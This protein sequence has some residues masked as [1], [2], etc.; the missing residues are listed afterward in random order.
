MTAAVWSTPPDDAAFS[1][2]ARTLIQFLHNHHLLQLTGK[3]NWLTLKNGS[4]SYVQRIVDQLP[5]GHLHMNTPVITVEPLANGGAI[6]HTTEK[7][8]H[9]DHV[10]FACHA[11]TTLRLLGSHASAEEQDILGCFQFGKNTAVL[12]SDESVSVDP[13]HDVRALTAMQMMPRLRSC[14][15][16]WNYLTFTDKTTGKPNVN[17][18]SL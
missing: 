5:Q 18:V 13:F 9:F 10:I 17:K 4:R 7:Q 16:A 15:A 3:P 8:E 12:H 11:D 1:F 2:P 14:W 6:V